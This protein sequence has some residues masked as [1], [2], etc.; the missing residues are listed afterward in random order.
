MS[1]SNEAFTLSVDM[2]ANFNGP[3]FDLSGN[4]PFEIFLNIRKNKLLE[5][6]LDARHL[7]ILRTG[8]IFYLRAALRKDLIQLTDETRG[9]RVRLAAQDQEITGEGPQ[10]DMSRVSEDSF[11]TLPIDFSKPRGTLLSVALDAAA[12]LRDVVEV[13][14]QYR[15]EFRDKNLGVQWWSWGSPESLFPDG[16]PARLPPGEPATMMAGRVCSRR[17]RVVPYVALPPKLDIRLSLTGTEL[18]PISSQQSKATPSS[19]PTA[20]TTASPTPI[21]TP[22][23]KLTIKNPHPFPLTLQTHLHQPYLSPPLTPPNPYPRI[24][25]PGPLN[26]RNFSIVNT[27]TAED[28]IRESWTCILTSGNAPRRRSQFLT[29]SPGE[30]VVRLGGLPVQRVVPGTEYRIRLRS[31]GC[32]WMKGTLDELFGEGKGVLEVK[33]QVGRGR[34]LP[35]MLECEDEV[36][37][38]PGG[39]DEESDG[40]VVFTPGTSVMGRLDSGCWSGS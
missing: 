11:I 19:P 8:S 2:Q 3:I 9:V 6:R 5:T 37:F 13:G 17:F 21:P 1:S 40:E 38:T 10:V 20:S 25:A 32:W 39:S 15:L 33:T 28:L 22:S 14:H 36:F 27:T 29:L 16:I 26:L 4:A 7:T 12:C 31:V 30:E 34:T 18:D 23:L 24:L 35:L